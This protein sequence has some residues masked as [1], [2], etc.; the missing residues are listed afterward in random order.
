MSENIEDEKKEENLSFEF[1]FAQVGITQKENIINSY[2]EK[3]ANK[4]LR[5]YQEVIQYGKKEGESL[6]IHV[7]NCIFV[8]ESISS[9]LDITDEEKKVIFVTLTLHDINKLPNIP[10]KLAYKHIATLENIEKEI[11]DLDIPDF[12]PE[13][14]EY[15]EDIKLLMLSHSGHSSNQ[16][17]LLFLEEDLTKIGKK[18]LEKLKFIVRA[19]DVSDLSKE[20]FE[21]SKKK[22]FLSNI[23]SFCDFSYSIIYHKINEQRGLLTN[24]IQKNVVEF[25]QENFMAIPVFNYPEGT[26]YLVRT[27]TELKANKDFRNEIGFRVQKNLERLK[28]SQFESYIGKDQKFGIK[29]SPEILGLASIREIFSIVDIKI[30]KKIKNK[31]FDIKESKAKDD[32][33]KE[34][35]NPKNE[36]EKNKYISLL[37]R[38]S[39]FPTT[40]ELMGLGELIRTFYIFISEHFSKEV[41]ALDKNYKEEWDY[42]YKV[43]GT[44]KEI[45]DLYSVTGESKQRPYM[46]AKDLEL[47]YDAVLEKIVASLEIISA[48][49]YNKESKEDSAQ[50]ND[51]VDYVT[52]NISFSFSNDISYDFKENF[53]NYVA[54]NHKQCSCCNS[55]FK[56][57]RMSTADVAD[58]IG[59]QQFSNRLVGGGSSAPPKRNICPICKEQF[60]LEKITYKPLNK[61]KPIYLHLYPHSFMPQAFL[62]SLRNSFKELLK[63]ELSTFEI[64]KKSI[65]NKLKEGDLLSFK[66]SNSKSFGIGAP[67]F[68]D[69]VINNHITLPINHYDSN[70]TENYLRFIDYA[71]LI[72]KYFNFKVLITE[73][74]I[75]NLTRDNFD[76]I[77]LDGLPSNLYGYVKKQNLNK[78][79]MEVFWKK[80]LAINEISNVLRTKD[81]AYT[82]VVVALN[83]GD[84]N[85]FHTIDRLIEKKSSNVGAAI[86][87]SR[88]IYEPLEKF[89]QLT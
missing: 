31:V 82:E 85:I 76:E 49:L 41:K 50:T 24:L 78:D 81:D 9:I 80:Y 35:N 55:P 37:S 60:A 59:V 63:F 33:I 13:W 73:S 46:I 38:D 70:V 11:L 20:F 18:R 74:I 5:K 58:G 71:I 62:M 89:I 72:N 69:E 79:D 64:D 86:S 84:N 48:H 40:Q 29:V 2:I 15:L 10:D 12:F 87:F 39:I 83:K 16:G 7:L 34:M 32:F 22:E 66:I 88:K 23:N 30:Q 65:L 54:N 77:Y 47:S 42:I 53:I 25:M 17:E 26:Y 61:N 28:A 57:E 44:E 27:S 45:I 52:K 51:L 21:E 43:L 3:I 36:S 4:K 8:V 1:L 19:A 68:P 14:K 6:Y 56:T 67:K 75:P